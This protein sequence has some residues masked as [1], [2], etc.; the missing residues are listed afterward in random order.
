MGEREEGRE[1]SGPYR[2]RG[3]IGRGDQTRDAEEGERS[4]ELRRE[5]EEARTDEILE[6]G[7]EEK[8]SRRQESRGGERD[9]GNRRIEGRK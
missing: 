5:K 8:R 6:G 7:R 9:S 2:A 4:V 3:A 1:D